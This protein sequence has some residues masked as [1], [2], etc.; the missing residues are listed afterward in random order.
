[1]TE[2]QLRESLLP[3]VDAKLAELEKFARKVGVTP[4]RYEIVER[5][6]V[7]VPIYEDDPYGP[8]QVVNMVKIVLVEEPLVL[9]G[10]WK[11]VGV[12][13]HLPEGNLVHVGPG[14]GQDGE[15]QTVEPTCDHCGQRRDRN[16]TILVTSEDGELKRVGSGCLAQYLPRFSLS[17][18]LWRL[19]AELNTIHD[20][21]WVPVSSGSGRRVEPTA[22]EILRW[23]VMINKRFGFRAAMSNG[24]SKDQ[25]SFLLN[26]F[27]TREDRE[28]HRE[29]VEAL[30][31]NTTDDEVADAML[32]LDDYIAKLVAQPSKTDFENN[33]VVTRRAGGLNRLGLLAFL[34]EAVRRIYEPL[35]APP[36]PTT[37]EPVRD[38]DPVPTGRIMVTGVVVKAY[39]KESDFGTQ[40]KVIVKD[41]RGFTVCGSDPCKSDLGRA[42]RGDSGYWQSVPGDRL[43]FKATVQ[44]SDRD[45]YFGFFKRPTRN[46]SLPCYDED[47]RPITVPAVTECDSADD[48]L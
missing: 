34:P 29:L 23:A 13:E 7:T 12:V 45:P 44:P 14:V 2:K 48:D 8:T 6:T 16:K 26:G 41:D 42:P 30:K 36:A 27:T 32:L 3:A 21:D 40:F 25:L 46:L 43:K 4:P 19:M 5:F 33:L 47:G 10:G 15:W 20:P 18:A 24:S 1:M 28:A 31:S 39:E 35:I 38:P 37:A 17:E 22:D 11:F 9:P